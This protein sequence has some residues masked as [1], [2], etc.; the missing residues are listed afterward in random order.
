[1]IGFRVEQQ[2]QHNG[3][4]LLTLP[5]QDGKLGTHE[6]ATS[7]HFEVERLLLRVDSRA[8]IHA[9][10]KPQQGFSPLYNQRSH[11]QTAGTAAGSLLLHLLLFIPDTI[12]PM[13]PVAPR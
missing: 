7:G 4:I 10:S 6:S 13:P 5:T 11:T 9:A 3:D 2:Q 8:D 1:M 12:H